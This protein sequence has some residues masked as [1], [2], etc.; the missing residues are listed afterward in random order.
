MRGDE[1]VVQAQRNRTES[2]S[3]PAPRGLLLDRNG[4][5]LATTRPA[6]A[7]SVVPK[8][9]PSKRREREE[10]ERILGTLAF[11]LEITPAEIE[12]RLTEA[13]NFRAFDPVPIK[14]SVDLATITR[15]EENGARLG[16]AVL[17]TNDLKRHYPQGRLASHILGYT[18]VVNERDLERAKARGKSYAFDDKIGKSGVER[19]YDAKIRGQ[20]GA[21][22]FEVDA[23]G[24]PLR[25]RDTRPDVPGATLKLTLDAKLQRAAE[26]A[27][28]KARNNGAIAA[29]DPRNGEVLALAS[30]PDFDPNMFSLSREEFSKA[31]RAI[32]A[33]SGKPLLNRAVVSA[34]PPG[35]TFKPITA[36]AGLEKGVV[37][38]GWS[39][40]CPGH[41]YF[42]RRFGCNAVH[43][44]GENLNE[45]IADSCN[46]YFYQLSL[47]FGD[48]S[49]S[50]PHYLAGVARRF[51]LGRDSGI[52]LPIDGKGLIPDPDWRRRINKKR[53][54]LA[55]WQ[56]G[57][58]L[59][60][61]IGQG[62]VLATP[63]QMALMTGAIANGGTLYKPRL[64]REIVGRDG[65]VLEKSAP[66]GENVGIS[67]R[68]ID[69]VRAG[70]RSV[71]VKG[72]GR[73]AAMKHVAVAG[74]TGSAQDSG[75]KRAHSWWICFAPYENPRIAIAAL[76]ENS[77][78][79]SEN[80]L[81]AAQ[82]V[83]KAAFPAPVSE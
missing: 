9:L 47:K 53:P 37:G 63:L 50:G 11:L 7:I 29:I 26:S 77:G 8:L 60:M 12:K 2:V 19:F 24:K 16:R 57:N 25:N 78:H 70:M 20:R 48:P 42:G 4:V 73:G 6:Y 31:Y 3:L 54:D 81:P 28:A 5:V 46:V 72:T 79:G 43:G 14:E 82:E 27:L 30:R 68:N 64:M 65:K 17:V 32:A 52:D 75:G 1:F 80:A 35:S 76:V 15:I 13:V 66:S 18:G 41:Y 74:K 59:N 40:S 61:S 62:D 10:R 56:P 22:I 38:P 44:G 69:L 83:L 33:N 23:M 36:S 67:R 71:V 58:T 21:Q 55:F 34:L 39:V 49:S 51:G 45:A